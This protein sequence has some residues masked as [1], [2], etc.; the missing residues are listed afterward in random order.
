MGDEA[1][2]PPSSRPKE[3]AEDP[4]R[5]AIVVAWD[6]EPR[7]VL[8]VADAVEDA[9]AETTARLRALGLEAALLTG[10]NKAAG[11]SQAAPRLINSA[12]RRRKQEP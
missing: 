4:G 8:E 2:P 11:L 6:G 10:D 3:Q 1:H 9:S 12:M 5:T 7:A